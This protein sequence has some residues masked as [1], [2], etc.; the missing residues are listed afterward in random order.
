MSLGVFVCVGKLWENLQEEK[1]DFFI[2]QKLFQMMQNQYLMKFC[3]GD[4]HLNRFIAK[5][6]AI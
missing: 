4:R 2:F 6:Q 1:S 3:E 5:I